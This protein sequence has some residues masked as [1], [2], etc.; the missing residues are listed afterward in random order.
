MITD[1]GTC[2]NHEDISTIKMV[3]LH[4]WCNHFFMISDP[5][6]DYKDICH[7]SNSENCGIKFKQLMWLHF[8]K[9]NERIKENGKATDYY[10]Y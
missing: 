6:V 10:R 2:G 9:T 3:F 4:L 1:S 8:L 5:C 7:D